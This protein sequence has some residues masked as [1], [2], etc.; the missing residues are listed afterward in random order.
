MCL[1]GRS[2]FAARP[3]EAI[4]KGIR[5]WILRKLISTGGAHKIRNHFFRLGASRFLIQWSF[6]RSHISSR[7]RWPQ[8]V[9][10]D[11]LLLR[12]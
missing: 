4:M 1:L 10:P 7:G 11:V 9:L 5:Q 3:E 6:P 8:G 12:M 2:K